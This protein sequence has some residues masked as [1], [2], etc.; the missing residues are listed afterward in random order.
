MTAMNSNERIRRWERQEDKEG[1]SLIKLLG[2]DQ[3]KMFHSLA[4]DG[5]RDPPD[6]SSKFMKWIIRLQSLHVAA[7]QVIPAMECHYLDF[8][9]SSPMASYPKRTTR[10]SRVD[11][12]SYTALQKDQVRDPPASTRTKPG[13]RGCGYDPLHPEEGILHS[14]ERP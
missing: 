8:T 4:T 13:G 9:G 3:Q 10:Q 1:K 6:T 5:L 7:N 11:Y 2:P 14:S 12:P